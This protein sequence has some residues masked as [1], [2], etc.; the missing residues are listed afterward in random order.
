MRI[1]FVPKNIQINRDRYEFIQQ[2]R[3]GGFMLISGSIYWLL[4]FFLSY[5]LKDTTLNSFYIWGGLLV[6]ILGLVI[7]KVLKLNAK[8]SQ[9]TSLV[10]FA[11]AM[12]P[13]CFPIVLLIESFNPSIILPVLCIINAPHLLVLCWIHLDYLY[14]ILAMLGICI[15]MFFIYSVPNHYMYF[16]A[17]AWGV[18]SLI[19]GLVIHKSTNEPLKEY[20]Y[21]IID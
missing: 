8:P 5:Y 1:P 20:D 2:Y 10:A 17:L 15:G 6:P 7:Y 21:H 3:G 11:S 9:Y 13:C 16:I 12:T 18:I 4:S 19:S 14:S